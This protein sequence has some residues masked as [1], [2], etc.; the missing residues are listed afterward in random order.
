MVRSTPNLR[1]TPSVYMLILMLTLAACGSGG[2]APQPE[3]PAGANTIPPAPPLVSAP[4]YS[5]GYLYGELYLDD[6]AN[7]TYGIEILM[8]EDGQFRALQLGPYNHP[9]TYMLL[10]GSFALEGRLIS[11]EGVAIASPGET[12]SDG[13]AVTS[14]SISGTLDG[15]NSTTDG[16]MLITV[17]M[18]SGDSGRIDAKYA[19]NS[20]YWRGS[21]L[22]QL[23]GSWR[24]E[25]N[26]DGSWYPDPYRSFDP[27]LAPPKFL[28]FN[29]ANVGE[30][31]GADDDGCVTAG[32]FSL[33][34]TR[35]GLWSVDY[36]IS[37]C[38]RAGS[39]SGLSLRDNG[40]YDI[41]SLN[42]SAD[43]G[44]RSQVLELWK[45]T[46]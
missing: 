31:S 24:A 6:A 17:S 39:Y 22:E 13:A 5:S 3:R 2:S 23:E 30:F 20:G 43:D 4:D 9:Q 42:F 36:T 37:D 16:K 33:I 10:R 34:D 7:S 1:T 18:A 14:L 15:P 8:S 12:W 25:Q 38:D 35:Y 28:E 45:E 40:W 44:T 11:G 19:I 29:V 21:D 27:P 26:A 41:P 46:S 32:H